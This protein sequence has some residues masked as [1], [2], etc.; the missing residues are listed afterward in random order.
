MSSD[1]RKRLLSWGKRRC[2]S[3]PKVHRHRR[4]F[5]AN[6][7]RRR[8]RP[9]SPTITAAVMSCQ[10]HLT[11]HMLQLIRTNIRLAHQPCPAWRWC[12]RL[13]VAGFIM[14]RSGASLRPI[15]WFAGFFA[16]IVVSQVHRAFLQGTPHGE[17]RIR[18]R[19]A[20]LEQLA[21]SI[22]PTAPP[23]RIPCGPK[24]RR[25]TLRPGRWQLIDARP[26]FG[27]AFAT[28]G[29]RNSPH[30]PMATPS[31]S[32]RLP[33]ALPPLKRLWLRLSPRVRPES[34]RRHGRFSQR[35][36]RHA[37]PSATTPT[38]C[39]SATW[40]ACGPAWDDAAIRARDDRWRI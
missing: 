21:E 6:A 3:S 12:A 29:S 35:L 37:V 25:S 28:A 23:P 5:C 15:L 33:R 22:N 4:G 38:R 8:T 20:A 14:T 36:R 32:A 1:R 9:A 7:R 39:I 31:C 10:P 30:C 2:L 17:S 11:C 13:H 16:L 26:M 34:T 40:S 27:E 18:L 19:T 24:R